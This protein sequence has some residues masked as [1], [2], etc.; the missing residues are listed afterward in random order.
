MADVDVSTGK[1]T[2]YDKRAGQVLAKLSLPSS[3]QPVSLCFLQFSRQ[4]SLAVRF[5]E[6][7]YKEGRQTSL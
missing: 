2:P 1:Q 3:L 4:A 6:A 5:S 7:G